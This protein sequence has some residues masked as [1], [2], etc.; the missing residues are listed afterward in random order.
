MMEHILRSPL[1][2]QAWVAWM[3][4][5]NSAAV[6]FLRHVQARWCSP[7]SSAPRFSCRPCTR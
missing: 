1:W 2:L 3:G 7:R 5:V 6:V 4:L